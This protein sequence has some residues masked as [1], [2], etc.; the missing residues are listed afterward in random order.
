MTERVLLFVLSL[1][2]AYVLFCH[3][4]EHPFFVIS[5]E[6][7]YLSFRGASFSVI[8]RSVSDEKS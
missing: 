6:Y 3:F 8:S 1:R 4:E 5:K 7:F 2:K